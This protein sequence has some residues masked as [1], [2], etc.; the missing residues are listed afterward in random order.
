MRVVHFTDIHFQ[1]DPTFGELFHIK[2]LMGSTNL[3]LLGRKSKFSL[4]AQRA[5]VQH[6]LN[7]KPDLVILT[8]DLTAQALDSEFALAKR[9]LSPILEQFPT[10]IQ[11]GNHDTYIHHFPQNMRD[12]FG[13]NLV[14]DGADYREFGTV[15]VLTVESCRPTLLS[16]GYVRP[17]SLKKASQLL[18]SATA[19]FIFFCMHYPLLNRRGELYGPSTRN[20]ANTQEV[21][22]WLKEQRKLSAFLHGHEH[23]GYTTPLQ[24]ASGE[25]PSINP[26]VSGYAIDVK[27]QRFPHVACYEVV[28]GAL[29]NIQRYSLQDMNTGYQA[30]PGEAFSTR[31]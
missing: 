5:T 15:G 10:V 4:D 26:G 12:A 14:Q 22:N 16:N 6:V 24:T 19:P 8:G 3:Y 18:E 27:Q 17:E 20:I 11:A 29:T 9:E 25:I 23:H 7:L 28:D 13:D 30:E 21:L 2:R 31:L 1:Q